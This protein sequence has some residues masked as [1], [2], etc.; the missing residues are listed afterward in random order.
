MVALS[1]IEGSF[2]F[3]SESAHTD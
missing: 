2:P 3:M 1:W